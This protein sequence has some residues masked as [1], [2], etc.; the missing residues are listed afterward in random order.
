[1]SRCP[2]CNHI[3]EDK[4]LKKQGASLMGKASGEAK[5]RTRDQA[6]AASRVR[7]D[8]EREKKKE[9]Q[10]FTKLRTLAGV[11]KPKRKAKH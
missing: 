8:Q 10:E 9:E 7:W 3:L 11:R 2:F 4:W 1:M 6:S 5:A